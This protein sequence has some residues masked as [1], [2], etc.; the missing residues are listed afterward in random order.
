MFT[1]FHKIRT[2]GSY[3]G[4]GGSL[5]QILFMFLTCLDTLPDVNRLEVNKPG[6]KVERGVQKEEVVIV[7]ACQRASAMF[8]PLNPKFILIS[9][10]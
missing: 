5:E 4:V 2:T 8:L 10:P 1:T 7:H 9:S 6:G 3:T